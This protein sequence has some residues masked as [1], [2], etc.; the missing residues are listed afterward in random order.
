[1]K[2]T[3]I[4]ATAAALALTGGFAAAQTPEPPKDT[5]TQSAVQAPPQPAAADATASTTT[6]TDATTPAATQSATPAASVTTTMVTNGP[7][8]DTPENR[9]KYGQPLSNAGKKTAARGN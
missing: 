5:P 8:P 2:L 1:M 3:P 9:A 4:L 6:T 7:V